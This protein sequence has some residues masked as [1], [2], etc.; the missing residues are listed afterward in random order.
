L[1]NL[2]LSIYWK[3]FWFNHYKKY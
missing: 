2:Y 3:Q 1:D